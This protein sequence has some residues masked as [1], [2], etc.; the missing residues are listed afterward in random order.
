MGNSKNLRV[1]KFAILLKSR[2]F[3]ARKIYMFCSHFY[4]SSAV[5]RIFSTENGR[6]LALFTSLVID[7]L[8]G[9]S[10]KRGHFFQNMR[11]T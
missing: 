6:Q 11:T 3:D 1:F 7:H 9:M 8:L 5:S 4:K 10:E 2:K